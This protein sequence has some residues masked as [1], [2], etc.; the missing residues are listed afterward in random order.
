MKSTHLMSLRKLALALVLTLTSNILLP[1][2]SW[3]AGID[4][5]A[6]VEGLQCSS[7]DHFFQGAI[8]VRSLSGGISAGDP[9]GIG[10]GG[11]R[12]SP[13]SLA[14]LKIAKDFDQCSPLLFRAAV[15]GQ[16]FP[17]VTISFVEEGVQHHVFFEIELTDAM[18]QDMILG[19]NDSLGQ[20][21]EEVSFTF[22]RIKLTDTVLRQDGKAGP[23]IVVECDLTTL[24][25]S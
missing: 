9:R 25:C 11:L 24:K 16:A 8:I 5:F 3:T 23:K 1:D 20:T 6:R 15:T 21:A 4:V 22:R 2:T 18:V 12:G 13:P 17:R 10:L 7:T 14:P 19:A